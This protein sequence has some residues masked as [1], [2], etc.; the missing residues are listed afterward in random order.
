M[1]SAAGPEAF[2][3]RRSRE[4]PTMDSR[5]RRK[6][7]GAVIG[8]V[9]GALVGLAAFGV[10]AAIESNGTSIWWWLSAAVA[11]A[12]G[13]FVIAELLAAE[14]DDGEIAAARNAKHP[15]GDADA[16][17]EGAERR[18]VGSI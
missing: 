8:P 5:E 13:G 11:G 14:K 17:V 12:I 15:V 3:T 2:S 1:G 7:K 16:P 10:I 9:V 18:D 6:L 4:P